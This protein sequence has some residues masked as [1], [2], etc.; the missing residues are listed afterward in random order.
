M[1]PA[2]LPGRSTRRAGNDVGAGPEIKVTASTDLQVVHPVAHD[3]INR[4]GVWADGAWPYPEMAGAVTLVYS[5]KG[6]DQIAEVDIALNPA[7]AW[8][9]D[10]FDDQGKYDLENIVTHEVGH[11]LGLVD[12][13]DQR[14]ATMFYMVLRGETLK[15]DLSE[16]DTA[17][18]LELYEGIDVNEPAIGCNHSGQQTPALGIVL[19]MLLA[20]M[21]TGRRCSVQATR[22][23]Q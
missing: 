1:A 5:A 14:E 3:G 18:L 7:F 20:A 12:L 9:L 22:R 19:L 4:V 16:Q 15:R 10:P 11:A 13:K 23:C 21:R 8:T 2:H 17:M 6:D